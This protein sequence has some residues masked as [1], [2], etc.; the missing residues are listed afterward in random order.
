MSDNCL[1]NSVLFSNVVSSSL[2]CFNAASVAS[3]LGLLFNIILCNTS[4]VFIPAAA[5]AIL[6]CGIR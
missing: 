6:T 5:N 2:I 3:L 4:N 1:F